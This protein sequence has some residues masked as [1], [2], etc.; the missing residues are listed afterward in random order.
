MRRIVLAIVAG[1]FAW[2]IVWFG[3]EMA[4]SAIWPNSYGAQQRAFQAAIENSANAPGFKA[5]TSFLLTH[6]VCA[7][8]A[9][10]IAGFLAALIARENKRAPIILGLLLLALSLL[11]AIWTWPLVPTWY[12]IAFTAVL[13]LMPILGGRLNTAAQSNRK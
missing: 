2:L 5:E 11:K 8:I 3:S 13:F 4:L 7:S 10:L 9:S 1:F 6:I 12:H